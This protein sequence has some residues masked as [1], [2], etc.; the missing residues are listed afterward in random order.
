MLKIPKRLFKPLR[1]NFKSGLVSFKKF[2]VKIEI[3][4]DDYDFLR[5]LENLI[6]PKINNKIKI[7]NFD[8]ECHHCRVKL[9]RLE[10]QERL[11]LEIKDLIISKSNIQKIEMLFNGHLIELI[12]NIH[13]N[14]NLLKNISVCDSQDL[15]DLESKLKDYTNSSKIQNQELLFCYHLEKYGFT[16]L[17]KSLVKNM[18]IIEKPDGLYYVYQL[19]GTQSPPDIS[20]FE[21]KDNQKINLIHFD[22]KETNGN[23][24]VLNDGWFNENTI[25]ILNF[26][27]RKK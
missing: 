15:K 17:H 1:I 2:T 14:P 8:D 18:D 25:Y 21:I 19:N 7:G 23:G 27:K 26:K 22:L 13:E 20:V 3:T 16:F 6:N 24:I 4:R 12:K 11:F 9:D 10:I 5:D